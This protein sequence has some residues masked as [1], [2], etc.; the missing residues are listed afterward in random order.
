M[1][2]VM[3]VH[4]TD[5]PYVCFKKID[6]VSEDIHLDP[7]KVKVYEILTPEQEINLLNLLSEMHNN[8]EY[9]YFEIAKETGL[10]ESSVIAYDL[11]Y[12]PITEED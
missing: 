3:T 10:K 9:R 5:S 6:M 11:K 1:K 2:D 8:D 4:I 12:F 7:K